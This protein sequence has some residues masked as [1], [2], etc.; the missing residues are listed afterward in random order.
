MENDT[1][2]YAVRHR[3]YGGSLFS[4]SSKEAAEA[5]ILGADSRTATAGGQTESRYFIAEV[6]PPVEKECRGKAAARVLARILLA[7]LIDPN[8]LV[9]RDVYHYVNACEALKPF[10]YPDIDALKEK[11]GL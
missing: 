11:L 5:W 9:G 7:G 4:T 10:G 8:A 2:V 3:N 6:S 1:K